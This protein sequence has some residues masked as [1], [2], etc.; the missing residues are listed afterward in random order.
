MNLWCTA[1]YYLDTSG[2]SDWADYGYNRLYYFYDG[3][4]IY[5]L[6]ISSA[7]ELLE[8]IANGENFFIVPSSVH[9]TILVPCED[10]LEV[11]RL[12]EMVQEVNA[13]QVQPEEVL[14]DHV[15]MYDALKKEV[16]QIGEGD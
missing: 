7:G 6:G 14:A 16:M 3:E 2:T 11:Q 8:S 5:Y 1:P 4:D 12:N 15:Y 13:T 10:T 9:E